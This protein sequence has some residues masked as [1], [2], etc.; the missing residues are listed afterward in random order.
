MYVSTG[1]PQS[2]L[3]SAKMEI[4]PQNPLGFSFVSLFFLFYLSE[5]GYCN[6]I[7]HCGHCMCTVNK[8]AI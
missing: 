3:F 1:S 4:F 6:F 8:Y 5:K 7:F 2:M